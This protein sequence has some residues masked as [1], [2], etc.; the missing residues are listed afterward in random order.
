[1]R[2]LRKNVSGERTVWEAELRNAEAGQVDCERGTRSRLVRHWGAEL[3]MPQLTV[4][5]ARLAK[6]VS[7]TGFQDT[8]SKALRMVRPS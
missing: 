7:D 4:I 8:L 6:K 1:M 3:G 2:E 5:P